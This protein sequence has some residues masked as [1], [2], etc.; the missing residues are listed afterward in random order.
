MI[1]QSKD[2]TKLIRERKF[3]EAA[4]E[5]LKSKEYTREEKSGVGARYR[6]L[7]DS[8]LKYQAELDLIAKNK[9]DNN[10]NG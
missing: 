5:Y 6:L 8:L 9:K 4:K 1:S 2:T 7:S 10:K 3:G